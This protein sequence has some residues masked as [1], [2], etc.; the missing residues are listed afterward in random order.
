MTPISEST[1]ATSPT[2]VGGPDFFIVGAPKCGTSSMHQYLRQHPD[3]YLPDLKDVPFFGSDLEHTVPNTPADREEY[4]AWFSEAPAG[5]R[6]GDSCTLYMQ[7]MKAAEDIASWRPDASIIVML[8]DPVDLMFS[9]HSHNIWMTEEDILDFEAAIAAEPDRRGG[10][11]I[12]PLCNYPAGLWYRDVASLGDQVARYLDVFPRERIHAI[13]FDEFRENARGVVDQ[14]L[15]FLGVRADVELDLGIVNSR[16]APRSLLVQR[17]FQ[18]PPAA[19]EHAFHALTPRGLHGRLL[20]FL[21]RFNETKRTGQR[22]SPELRR[23][24][25]TEMRP[26]VEKLEGLIGRN[27][28]SWRSVDS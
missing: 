2:A 19:L 28:A 20:P 6:V 16:R 21:N 27:L 9:L 4:L 22:L 8:R 25:E 15:E 11:R 13:I 17:F 26:Q 14:T 3:L 18:Q 7:S 5:A 24:L 10:R 23:Q 1:D 12:P